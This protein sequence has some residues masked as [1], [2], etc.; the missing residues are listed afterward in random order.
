MIKHCLLLSFILLNVSLGKA[1]QKKTFRTTWILQNCSSTPK[2]KQNFSSKEEQKSYISRLLHDLRKQGHLEASADS[3]ISDSTQTK[4]Y[5]HCGPIYKW[6][7]LRKGNAD[8][9]FL[10]KAGYHE[11]AFADKTFDPFS[12]SRMIRKLL[13]AYENEG[14]P[15][16]EISFDS[17][18]QNGPELSASLNVRTNHRVIIDSIRVRGNAKITDQYLFNYT[19][20]KPGDLYNESIISKI[21]LRLKEI[22]FIQ[23]TRPTEIVFTPKYTKV[24]IYADRKKANQFDGILGFLPDEKGSLLVTGQLHMNLHNS[25]NK[26]E[27]I[28]LNWKKLQPLTQDLFTRIN[29]PF[30]F[31]TPF[32][33]ELQ[34]HI[35]KRDTTYIDVKKYAALQYYLKRGTFF[36]L[37]LQDK[38]T[39][40]LSVKGYE[41]ITTLPEFADVRN[42]LYGIGFR[43]EN[44][45]Y[46]FNPRSGF[47]LN[48]NAGAGSRSIKRNPRINQEAYSN[49]DLKS[50]QYQADANVE[51]FI[52][53]FRNSTIRL[54][55]SG[56][57]LLSER[58]FFSELFRI[59]GLR[60]LRGFDEESIFASSY[61]IGTFEYR[62]LIDQNSYVHAFFDQAA[63]Q[64][65]LRNITDKPF[66]FGAGI[67]FETKAGIFSL[68]YAL[69]K[70]LNNP[71]FLRSAKVHFGIVNYF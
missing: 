67:S 53:M 20:I 56:A 1:Q 62:L 16:A 35:Y 26:G 59:G 2:T 11:K 15:F 51:Y 14:F 49:V 58:Y 25:L 40:L 45:D 21:D 30:L 19:S 54:A 65:K 61:A 39:S 37:F 68:T 5:I 57:M 13:A 31:K 29:Y 69:G 9:H 41:F 10:S 27:I 38:S 52:P 60:S 33:T 3:I 28:E 50:A 46:R 55:T 70:Q 34:L 42:R 4:I 47:V 17:I 64:N 63:Y 43:A 44:L 66:G 48:L 6:V 71:I 23:V 32:G 36:K 22:P 7:K 8:N 24:V 18:V 12:Y